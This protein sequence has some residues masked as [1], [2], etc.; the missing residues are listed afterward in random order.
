MEIRNKKEA[1][2]ASIILGAEIGIAVAFRS[3][4]FYKDG[5]K[6]LENGESETEALV[7]DATAEQPSPVHNG[8]A[9]SDEEARLPAESSR[10]VSDT[11]PGSPAPEGE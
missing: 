7:E 2:W 9:P 1:V 10:E 11:L 4:M 8:T 6:A 5:R 3:Y